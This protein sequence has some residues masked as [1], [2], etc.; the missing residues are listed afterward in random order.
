MRLLADAA[1]GAADGLA[2]DGL[3]D[4]TELIGQAVDRQVSVF[5][6]LEPHRV[7]L[8]LFC[9]SLDPIGD[10]SELFDVDMNHSPQMLF[11]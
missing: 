4:S 2:A 8:S 1:F 11:S 10:T 3:D 5:D 6:E 7:L 9:L